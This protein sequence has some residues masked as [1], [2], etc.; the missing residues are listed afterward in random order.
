M[1]PAVVDRS[2]SVRPVGD[3]VGGTDDVLADPPVQ[4]EPT[5]MEVTV[6][7]DET[8]SEVPIDVSLGAEAV[9]PT[10]TDVLGR[11]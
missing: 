7:P 10:A 2:G 11:R 4:P 1:G 8:V 9:E 6:S 5:A 3:D